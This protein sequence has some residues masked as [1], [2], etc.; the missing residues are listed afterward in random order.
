MKLLDLYYW[1]KKQKLA[2]VAADPVPTY[3]GV[4]GEKG[5]KGD[6]GEPGPQGPEGPQGPAGAAGSGGGPA[7]S[8]GNIQLA[9][10]TIGSLVLNSNNSWGYWYR[11]GNFVWFSFQIYVQSTTISGENIV[12]QGFPNFAG[13]PQVPIACSAYWA[14]LRNMAGKMVI[15]TIVAADS[16]V[17]V[18]LYATDGNDTSELG[19]HLQANANITVTGSF[20]VG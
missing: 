14:A 1:R 2:P 9:I 20:R 6:P 11:V 8:Q 16:E 17:K 7:V 18:R 5:D 19:S 15:A 13:V 10:G 12:V 4:Q 3:Y